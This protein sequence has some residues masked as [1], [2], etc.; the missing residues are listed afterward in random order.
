MFSAWFYEKDSILWKKVFMLYCP[1]LLI[2]VFNV[3][4]L[5]V[6]K[7]PSNG[8]DLKVI[9]LIISI[10]LKVFHYYFHSITLLFM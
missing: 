10:T 8:L 3:D 4:S 2:P 5:S 9:S 1:C 6:Y 7:N